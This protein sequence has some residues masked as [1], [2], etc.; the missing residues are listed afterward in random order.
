MAHPKHRIHPGLRPFTLTISLL[1]S[2]APAVVDAQVP[3]PCASQNTPQEDTRAEFLRTDLR[4][5]LQD[6]VDATAATANSRYNKALILTGSASRASPPLDAGLC[7]QYPKLCVGKNK[8]DSSL[9]RSDSSDICLFAPDLAVC[10]KER[11]GGGTIG[12]SFDDARS[13]AFRAAL[14][15]IGD[16]ALQTRSELINRIA[17]DN[18]LS[19]LHTG[20]RPAMAE[21]GLARA[22]QEQVLQLSRTY[23]HNL[24]HRDC[25]VLLDRFYV[26]L[27]DGLP[28]VWQLRND[29]ADATNGLINFGLPNQTVLVT[30][31]GDMTAKANWLNQF[32]THI[33][34]SLGV[35]NSIVAETGVL[36]DA[37]LASD[38]GIR[39][40]GAE[41]PPRPGRHFETIMNSSRLREHQF[42]ARVASVRLAVDLTAFSDGITLLRSG[43]ASFP[44]GGGDSSPI[45]PTV[46]QTLCEGSGGLASNFVGILDDQGRIEPF[47]NDQPGLRRGDADLIV[48]SVVLCAAR[49]SLKDILD[50]RIAV[51]I[52]DNSLA[53]GMSQVQNHM[54]PIQQRIVHRKGVYL[55]AADRAWQRVQALLQLVP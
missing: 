32:R 1:L 52:P 29:L 10:K 21:Y 46:I 26:S 11:S 55:A 2:I 51:F 36:F 45:G 3:S 23:R 15:A 5:R 40:R 19:S 50:F 39:D 28:P 53:E 47:L 38:L 24:K 13:A 49:W 30:L 16:S 4:D 31:P 25:A 37:M 8:N 14:I 54:P 12:M 33:D 7:L 20:V 18:L 35:A 22:I 9:R 34:T 41:I 43:L 27:V 48:T 17:G 6:Y 42:N 44:P